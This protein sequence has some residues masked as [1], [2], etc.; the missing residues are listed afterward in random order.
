M[1]IIGL[2]WSLDGG[3]GGGGKLHHLNRLLR[4]CGL[5]GIATGEGA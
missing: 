2:P 3:G 4:L 1:Q 5:P